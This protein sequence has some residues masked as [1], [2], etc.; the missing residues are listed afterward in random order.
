VA[1][2]APS[3]LSRPPSH[4]VMSR[5][6]NRPAPAHAVTCSQ[7]EPAS[8]AIVPRNAVARLEAGGRARPST[9]RRLAAVLEVSQTKLMRQL[10]QTD[11]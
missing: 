7:R 10:P 3:S 6:I 11:R 5:P 8:A 9:V 1:M 2:L 4:S